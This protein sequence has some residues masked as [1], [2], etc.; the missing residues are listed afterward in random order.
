MVEVVQVFPVRQ[1]VDPVDLLVREEA[2]VHAYDVAQH[3]GIAPV[4][5]GLDDLEPR[6]FMA[7]RR[8][9]GGGRSRRR[10]VAGGPE[11]CATVE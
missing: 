7:A 2:R 5:R 1:F 9:G 11:R 3:G 10:A 4:R 8:S 6:I